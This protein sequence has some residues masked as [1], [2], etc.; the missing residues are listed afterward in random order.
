MKR[1][2]LVL[3][4]AACAALATPSTTSARLSDLTAETNQAQP[5]YAYYYGPYRRACSP[6]VS[7]FLPTC[8]LRRILSTV[9][10]RA[11]SSACASSL[12]TCIQA[13]LLLT[14]SSHMVEVA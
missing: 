5:N 6:G 10:L 11:L 12:S 8:L 3:A 9:P 13:G 1:S 7:A 4:I 2:I 14:P